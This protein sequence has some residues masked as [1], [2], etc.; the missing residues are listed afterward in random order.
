M[1]CVLLASGSGSLTQAVLDAFVVPDPTGAPAP[2]ASAPAVAG[3]ASGVEI[4]AVGSDTAAAGALERAARAGIDTFVVAP[5]DHADRDAWNSALTAAVEAYRP[6]WVVSAGF[7]R[8]LGPE[9]V[10]R[11]THRI[12]NTHPALLPAFPGA[13]GVRDALAHGV[14][15]TGTTIHLVDTGVDTGPIIAQF[16]VAVRDDD[17]EDS[18][19]ERIRAV[20]RTRIVEL[21]AFLAE[22]PLDVS[23]RRVTGFAPAPADRT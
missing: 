1:R 18:L 12:I 2:T 22:H 23:G 15:V 5:R 19:H 4:V 8:I 6:D 17:T 9:F 13:H 10:T 21:L 7:M 20:E 11:F 16:P 14:K 3:P